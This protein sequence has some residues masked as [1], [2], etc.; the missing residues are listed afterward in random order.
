M[1]EENITHKFIP[2]RDYHNKLDKVVE[3]FYRPALAGGC[4]LYQRATG[5]FSSTSFVYVINEILEFIER[6]GRIQLVTSPNLS[7]TDKEMMEKC[8]QDPE[9]ILSE[10]SNLE[11]VEDTR[12]LRNS[13]LVI[14]TNIVDSPNPRVGTQ[15]PN[16]AAAAIQREKINQ[17]RK[18]IWQLDINSELRWLFITDNDFKLHGKGAK[19]RLL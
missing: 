14:T 7:R 1:P 9:K 13:M 19:R 3:E 8:I 10:I 18:L 11:G 16:E 4:I 15:W 12:L 2:K 17:L 6:R 5:Y